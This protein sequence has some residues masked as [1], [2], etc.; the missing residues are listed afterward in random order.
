[1]NTIK[2]CRICLESYEFDLKITV[3]KA[4]RY[5]INNKPIMYGA[6][7]VYCSRKK[8]N[9]KRRNNKSKTLASCKKYEKTQKGFLMRVYRNMKSRVTGIQK[10]KFHLYKGKYLLD[11][12]EFYSW[13]LNN[14]SFKTLFDQYI[15]SNYSRKLAPSVDRVDS[16]DGY[17]L[18]NMEWVT[19][20]ENSRRAAL[21]KS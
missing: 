7:C 14:E 8:L 18:K 12:E 9:E 17:H 2:K 13:S 4:T 3:S 5:L 21:K 19:M 1:M 15:K 6:T 16:S 11:K 20:S 10:K